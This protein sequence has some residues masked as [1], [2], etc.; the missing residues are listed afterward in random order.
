LNRICNA[1]LSSSVFPDGLQYAII[2]P[3]YK[4]G[5][6]QDISNYRP[7]YLLTSFSKVFEKLIYNRLYTHFEMKNILV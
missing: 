4:K 3:I 6:K 2:K 5:S 1:Y 7:I